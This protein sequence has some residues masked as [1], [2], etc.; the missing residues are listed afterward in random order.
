MNLFYLPAKKPKN[1]SKFL[2]KFQLQKIKVSMLILQGVKFA[3]KMCFLRFGVHWLRYQV[4]WKI[5]NS[6]IIFLMYILNAL[7][8]HF[9]S[10]L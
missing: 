2:P 10:K 6:V 7:Q 1:F 8:I 9:P 4:T 3:G 5:T